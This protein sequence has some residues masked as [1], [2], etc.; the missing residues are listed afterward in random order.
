MASP[1]E[2]R[3]FLEDRGLAQHGCTPVLLSCARCKDHLDLKADV[4]VRHKSPD[5]SGFYHTTRSLYLSEI[6][7]WLDRHAACAIRAPVAGWVE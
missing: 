3:R 2:I 7:E 4:R 1:D 5:G 6:V